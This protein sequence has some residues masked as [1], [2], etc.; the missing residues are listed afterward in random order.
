MTLPEK[1]YELRK[2]KGLT[3]DEVAEA[4][5]VSRQAVSK[6]EMGT[7]V[8]SVDSLVAISEFYGV[9]VDSLI[10]ENAPKPVMPVPEP[11]PEPVTETAACSAPP[12]QN[13]A[14]KTKNGSQNAVI[15]A[16]CLIL[17]YAL[18]ASLEYFASVAVN[19]TLYSSVPWAPLIVHSAVSVIVSIP[20]FVTMSVVFRC[21][22]HGPGLSFLGIL[23]VSIASRL[24]TFLPAYIDIPSAPYLKYVFAVL[25]AVVG[26]AAYLLFYLA[27]AGREGFRGRKKYAVKILLAAIIIYLLYRALFDS[28]SQ[29]FIGRVTGS[30]AL[31]GWQF[32]TV[33]RMLYILSVLGRAANF[34][35]VCALLA[36]FAV[37]YSAKDEGAPDDMPKNKKIS[38]TAEMILG[39]LLVT[40]GFAVSTILSGLVRALL[41]LPSGHLLITIAQLPCVLPFYIALLMAFGGKVNV[42]NILKLYAVR[43][44]FLL[45]DYIIMAQP[46]A[47]MARL[48]MELSPVLHAL[49]FVAMYLLITGRGHV[50]PNSFTAYIPP[51]VIA[52]SAIAAAVIIRESQTLHGEETPQ[53][54]YELYT[55][56]QQAARTISAYVDVAGLGVIEWLRKI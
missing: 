49:G 28:A 20:L 43:A 1:L 36:V 12:L 26:T 29:A 22:Y 11:I 23:G 33:G 56:T 25:N 55:V 42:K 6:W 4:L 44:V 5:G 30:S 8:P 17:S 48:Y 9:T 41:P 47:A 19:R 54:L 21:P 35:A 10:K 34:S 13:P 39:I 51:A 14:T 52:F 7:G 3:Q 18:T 32:A 46:L 38:G 50:N 45:L 40:G 24:F 31:D 16:V 53:R 37:F 27:A 15:I 2:A